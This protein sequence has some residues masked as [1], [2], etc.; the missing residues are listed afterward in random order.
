MSDLSGRYDVIANTPVGDQRMT[1]EITVE[2]DTFRGE[3]QGTMGSATISGTVEGDT[4]VWTQAITTPMP[5]ALT[6]RATVAGDMVHG[7]VDTGGFGSFPISGKR[8]I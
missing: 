6:C 8:S 1:I 7:S 2:G 3:S 5:L 4:L